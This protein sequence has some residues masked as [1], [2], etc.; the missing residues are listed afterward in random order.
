MSSTVA[1]VAPRL[2]VP[3]SQTVAPEPLTR[4]REPVVRNWKEPLESTAVELPA[5]HTTGAP[6]E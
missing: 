4:R 3:E 1:D 6:P 2:A 5:V